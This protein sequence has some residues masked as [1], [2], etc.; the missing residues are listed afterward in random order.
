MGSHPWDP[1]AGLQAWLLSNYSCGEQI[2]AHRARWGRY[3]PV[4]AALGS[5]KRCHPRLSGEKS[6]G[7]A[8]GWVGMT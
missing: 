1:E 4:H 3:Q 2:N 5:S 7:T 8:L 6:M